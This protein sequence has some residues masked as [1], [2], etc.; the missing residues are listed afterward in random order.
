MGLAVALYGVADVAEG[1]AWADLR[2]AYAQGRWVTRTR[3]LARTE[4]SPMK[5][6]LLVSPW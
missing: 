4:G 5:N 1:G 2:D 3:R 6:I